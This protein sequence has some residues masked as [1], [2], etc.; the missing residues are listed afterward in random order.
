VAIGTYAQLR[1]AVAGWINRTDL[2]SVIP[3]FVLLAEASIRRDIRARDQL[4][5]YTATLTSEAATL[6][7]DLL[8]IRW[9][10]ASVDGYM[11]PLEFVAEPVYDSQ[12]EAAEPT[13]YTVAGNT[14]KV[15]GGSSCVI[16][17]W[18][19]YDAFSADADT[20]WLLTNSPDVYLFASLVEASDYL[21]DDVAR[22]RYLER[23]KRAVA[24]FNANEKKALFSG[25]MRVRAA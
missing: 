21:R 15:Q 6:P 1:T 3:D 4:T 9:V 8:E 7:S 16:N 19:K 5:D 25:P 17:Y 11:K 10:K 24:E 2:T 18:A 14:I 20:N 12:P 22:D 23:Y 13:F